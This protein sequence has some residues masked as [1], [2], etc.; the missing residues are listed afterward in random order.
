MNA[1]ADALA[2]THGLVATSNVGGVARK[3]RVA[4]L[5]DQSFGVMLTTDWGA[6][7]PPAVTQMRL[8]PEA[9]DLLAQA[10]NEAVC[11]MHSY[12]LGC[13]K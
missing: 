2:P 10:L 11:N 12:E 5:A 1:P 4:K 3:V 8:C 13:A 6:G 7:R 9:L